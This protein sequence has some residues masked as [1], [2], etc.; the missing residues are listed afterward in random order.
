MRDEAGGRD[1]MRVLV[2]GGAGFIGSHLCEA[3][4][5]G[6]HRV[7][8][9]DSFLTGSPGNVAHLTG[10]P[11][12]SLIVGD[13]CDP[14]E[15]PQVVDRVFNLAGAASSRRDCADPLD[16]MLTNVLG[17]HNLLL[18]AER[19]GARFLQVST[20]GVYGDPQQHPQPEGYLGHVDC[21][22]PRAC[23][24]EGMRAAEAL[25]FDMLRLGRADVRVARIFNVY[26]PRM[27]R[28][29]GRVVP[30]FIVQ[31]LT[32][33][34]LTVYGSGRQTRSFCYVADIVRGLLALMD[35]DER[36]DQP[37]N[38]G[39]PQEIEVMDLARKVQLYTGAGR[40]VHEP[41]P[42]HDPGRRRPEISAAVRLLGWR[43][44]VELSEGLD[45]TVRHFRQALFP[46]RL[47]IP[48]VP[49]RPEAVP[50]AALV[51]VER[52]PFADPEPQSGTA[53]GPVC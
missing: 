13:V 14:I 19:H 1:G 11:R 41:L 12:F 7:V 26:G 43:P 23:S 52:Q 4:L 49:P 28:D 24:E 3:L 32:G 34:P 33:Q 15:P 30:N 45:L 2:A 25:C 22:G 9:L 31:A 36:P 40:I 18:L 8:C 42:D 27:A 53:R 47:T 50:R 44:V 16:T 20:A 35:V 17:T 46:R 48:Q 6:G 37:V 39:N 5:A 29:D 10:H 38:L 21:T 51:P